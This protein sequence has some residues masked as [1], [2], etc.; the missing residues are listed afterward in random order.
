MSLEV[1][2][3]LGILQIL[4]MVIQ[5]LGIAFF[6]KFHLLTETLLSRFNDHSIGTNGINKVMNGNRFISRHPQLIRKKSI[7]ATHT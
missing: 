5:G 6:F 2:L 4:F 3:L 7:P 1:A